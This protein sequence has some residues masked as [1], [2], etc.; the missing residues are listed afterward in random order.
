MKIPSIFITTLSQS[1]VQRRY[2]GTV[3]EHNLTLW[4]SSSWGRPFWVWELQEPL[5][6][7][8]VSIVLGGLMVCLSSS[9]H[10]KD[11]FGWQNLLYLESF[12]LSRAARSLSCTSRGL[13]RAFQERSRALPT[14]RPQT[15]EFWPQKRTSL[16]N[17]TKMVMSLPHDIIILATLCRDITVRQWDFPCQ[18]AGWL[19][20]EAPKSR[21]SP[22][23]ARGMGT[24]ILSFIC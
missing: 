2:Q 14:K 17:I 9:Q 12:I 18:L 22:A 21:G 16:C 15:V 4:T 20:G 3:V 19:W 1:Q 10:R 5:L 8:V 7:R 6:V 24:L 11:I 13:E 23:P